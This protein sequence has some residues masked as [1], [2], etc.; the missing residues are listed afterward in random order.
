[1]TIT[2]NNQVPAAVAAAATAPEGG[3]AA[4]DVAGIAGV[5]LGDAPSAVAVSAAPTNGTTAVAGTTVTYTANAFFFGNDSYDYTITD[6]DGETSTAT[7]SVT[8]GPALVP[9]ASDDAATV[10]QDDSVTI[11]VTANDTA[12]SG[13][14]AN[15]T[16]TVT[17]APSNGSTSVAVNN[18]VTYTP[19]AGFN[20]MDS[21]VYTLEDEDG[22][23]TDT[24]TVTID[25]DAS[26]IIVKLPGGNSA[27]DPWSL[28]LLL[29]G[30]PVLR[31][32]R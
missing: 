32:R 25:V 6:D 11:D 21:F 29:F 28:A 9:I 19:D 23:D 16:V 2:V 20:G 14:L 30:I 8:V 17:T 1:V 31:R 3:S 4:T 5:N 24:A 7:V 13:A 12:G 10:D 22:S 26:G 27:V 15:H 18:V